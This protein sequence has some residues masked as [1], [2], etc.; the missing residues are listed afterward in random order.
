VA[1]RVNNYNVICAGTNCDR[2]GNNVLLTLRPDQN[3]NQVL[4]EIDNTRDGAGGPSMQLSGSSGGQ[5]TAT[6]QSNLVKTQNGSLALN[7]VSYIESAPKIP[8]NLSGNSNSSNTTGL[9][10]EPIIV[11][12]NAGQKPTSSPGIKW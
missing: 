2:A 7:L 8:K 11:P 9:N 1:G 4:A 3:P 10:E 6:K 5:N 12:S